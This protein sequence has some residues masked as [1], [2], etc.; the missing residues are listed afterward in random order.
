MQ[1]HKTTI[2]ITILIT[3]S[4]LIPTLFVTANEYEED[5]K[6]EETKN[7]TNSK[8]I[9]LHFFCDE[10]IPSCTEQK[11][12]NSKLQK[13]FP[14]LKIKN[15][16]PFIS[17]K[18]KDIYLEMTSNL[19]IEPRGVPITII[20]NK[21]WEGF[22]PQFY[23]QMQEELYSKMNITKTPAKNTDNTQ[24][25]KD[26]NKNNKYNNAQINHNV[27]KIPLLA[28]FIILLVSLLILVTSIFYTQLIPSFIN[29]TNHQET[30]NKQNKLQKNEEKSNS[31]N[32]KNPNKENKNKNKK[33]K[34][35]NKTANSNKNNKTKHA[36]T[37][38]TKNKK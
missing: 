30:K 1:N 9:T 17:S 37:S 38:T 20:E 2:L 8:N 21:T 23:L 3:I 18:D 36:T 14:N 15:Y 35:K 19:N 10:T 32:K 7:Q 34:T 27:L 24:N 6:K 33:S 5:I 22:I 12:Y 4:L 29:T 28:F 25:I 16:Q 13:E 11:T 26:I 31:K